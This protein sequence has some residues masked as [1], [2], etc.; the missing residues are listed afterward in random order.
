[1]PSLLG[2]CG[3]GGTVGEWVGIRRQS[4][5]LSFGPYPAAD[6]N[7][8][9]DF[10]G[11]RWIAS[12]DTL[13]TFL[14]PAPTSVRFGPTDA[15]WVVVVEVL[16]EVDVVLSGGL[17]PFRTDAPGTFTPEGFKVNI[18]CDDT[19]PAI[20]GSEF[21]LSAGNGNSYN[22]GAAFDGTVQPTKGFFHATGLYCLGGPGTG[23]L[24][25]SVQP[26]YWSPNIDPVVVSA[27]MLRATAVP[28]S[29]G[30]FTI[31]VLP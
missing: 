21:G 24:F 22:W 30:L 28:Q 13:W 25:F 3:G 6:Y 29:L 7:P 1:V 11:G 15:A 31:P 20:T 10:T 17:A 26:A 14:E 5:G 18:I 19:Y 8:F 23:S 4:I 27:M 16:I 2:R 12:S 9:I